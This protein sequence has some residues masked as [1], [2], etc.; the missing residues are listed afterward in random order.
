MTFLIESCNKGTILNINPKDY[1]LKQKVDAKYVF[2]PIL[3]LYQLYIKSEKENYPLFESNIREYLGLR[4]TVNKG[5]RN[6]LLDDDDRENFFY[7]NNGITMIVKDIGNIEAGEPTTI[8][9]TNPQIVNGCQTVSTIYKTL[10]KLPEEEIERKFKD[11]YVML[12]ILKIPKNNTTL[13]QISK[14][15]VRFNN[16]QNSLDTKA[17]ESVTSEF[18][19]IQS[20]FLR[21]GFLV[22]IKQSDQHKFGEQY[23]N[24]SLLLK[25]NQILLDKF[26]LTGIKTAKNLMIPLIKLLQIYRSFDDAHDAIVNKSKFLVCTSS[27]YKEVYEFIRNP[28]ITINEQIHLLLLY[29]RVEQER[30]S[31]PA[32]NTINPY[33]LINCFAINECDSNPGKIT[34][35]LN[36][37]ENVD[38]II[39]Y[40]N[41]VLTIYFELWTNN[42][43]GKGYNDMVKNNIDPAIMKTAIRVTEASNPIKLK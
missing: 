19:R 3:N 42:N 26:G 37:K 32:L 6:T 25:E 21:K 15:I 9:V 29:L 16:S 27:Q 24:I 20:E 33:M 28:N 39:G 2:T 1:K 14:N 23:K 13:D 7:Y 38:S 35:V 17:F 34:S 43:R 40:Y 5:I 4:G 41:T 22:C 31:N 11:T 18:I 12:K 10:S 30:K 8:K 36:C